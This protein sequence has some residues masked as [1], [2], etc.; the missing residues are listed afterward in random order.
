MVEKTPMDFTLLKN[1]PIKTLELLETTAQ[2]AAF[3]TDSG[4]LRVSFY[5]PGILRMTFGSAPRPDYGL[6][7]SSPEPVPFTF[8]SEDECYR[9]ASEDICLEITPDPLQIRLRRGEKTL[10][11]SPNDGHITGARRLVAFAKDAQSWKAG[12][13]LRS[14][15][16]VYGL[17]EKWGSLNRRGQLVTSWNE[18]ALG[19]NSELAYKNLPFAWSPEGWG[20]YVNATGRITHGVGYA[21]WSHRTYLLGVEEAVLDL[22]FI[23]AASPAG[24]IERFTHLTGRSPIPPRWSFGVWMSRCYYRTA[25]EALAE[26]RKLREHH[27]PCDV[28]TLDGR[29]WLN[30]DTRFGFEWDSSRY[31]DPPAFK[32]L[33]EDLNLRLCV[34]EYP[35]VSTRAKIFPWLAEQG[36]LL[37][38]RAGETYIYHWDPEPFGQILSPLPDSGIFDFTNPAAYTWYR[39]AH[40]DLFD[41]G[42]DV[43]KPDFGEQV[44][45]DAVAYNGDSGKEL[46][47]IYAMLY[48][49]CVF[50]ATQKYFG[51]GMVW[52]RSAW[53]GSQRYPIQWGGDSQCDWEGLAASIRG[54][55]SWG[56]SGAPYHTSDIGGFYLGVPETELYIRWTQAGVFSSHTRF[57]GTGPREPWYFGEQ[58]E[59]IVR[60]WCELRYRLIPYLQSCAIE[61]ARTG[62]PVMRSMAL[63]FPEDR[64]AWS[65]EEQYLLG[66]S[67]LVAPVIQRG[68]MVRFYLPRGEWF[69]FWSGERAQGGR[70]IEAIYPIERI[71]VF[72]RSGSLLPL[73]PVV[74]HTGE[75]AEPVQIDEIRQYGSPLASLDLPGLSLTVRP[76]G[77]LTNLPVGTRLVKFKG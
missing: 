22:F 10:L 56:M 77:S 61:A 28:T 72:V 40:F 17:G 37:K 4:N 65:F 45:E 59:K 31:P 24:L 8:R 12:F 36:Y 75:L 71:P 49:R 43:I 25:E 14:G 1:R 9:F 51:E 35:L 73:G 52:S 18:D 57:H 38:N 23:A 29:A 62:M 41:S 60:E 6:L 26:A 46:H 33:L 76:D 42:I 47:N 66:P 58:A 16:P 63:A 67:L 13:A 54:G 64:L 2:G 5:A 34:W 7:A 30:V 53:T 68:G 70:L 27:I 48:N 50:E 74:Q 15:E 3:A 11:E 19:V 39:D 21:Q 69:D 20:L 44:P 32:Q 55:Q